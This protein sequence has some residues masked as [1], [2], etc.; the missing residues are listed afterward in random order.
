MDAPKISVLIPT[1]N[2][3][4]F[5]PQAIESVLNQ[6]FRDFELIIGDD[7]STDS[8]AEV[9]R[10]FAAQDARIRFNI[11]EQN[12][13]M[14]ENWNWCLAQAKGVYVKYLFGDDFLLA[15]DAL[16]RLVQLVESKPGIDLAASA[17]TVV[18]DNSSPVQVWDDMEQE[19]ILK[20]EKVAFA[21]LK[22]YRNLIGEPSVVLFRREKAQ[23]GFDT[24]FR[25]AVDLELWLHLLH[26]GGD[27]AYTR[28]PL[29]AFRR[30]SLQQTAVNH[31]RF[32][33]FVG[34]HDRIL[35]RYSS[36]YLRN[37]SSKQLFQHAYW[38]QKKPRGRPHEAEIRDLLTRE[39]GARY[40]LY[41]LQMR[42]I[43]LGVNMARAWRKHVLRQPVPSKRDER[44]VTSHR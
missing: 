14:V 38:M 32:D 3:A 1:Y 5:L 13:G 26:Q 9:I 43:K 22:T 36:Y 20:G 23:R 12:L 17:R 18:D 37:E 2:Y 15:T 35:L 16:E 41:W 25:Q 4:R 34:E 7:N 30:H 8:S 6:S 19:G 28:T 27:V 33:H 40:Y 39:L 44:E 10:T 31:Q 42:F 29:C 24:S 11:H 21:C